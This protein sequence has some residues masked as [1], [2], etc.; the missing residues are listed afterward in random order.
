MLILYILISKDTHRIF[1]QKPD[2]DNGSNNWAVSGKKQ[3]AVTRFYV[4]IR[5]LV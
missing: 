1:E 4:T 3:K 2:K 5:I